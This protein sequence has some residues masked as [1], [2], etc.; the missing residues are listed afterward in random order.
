MYF[1]VEPGACTGNLSEIGIIRRDR[2]CGPYLSETEPAEHKKAGYYC[3]DLIS[4]RDRDFTYL[5]LLSV[6]TKHT[7][8]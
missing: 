8:F 3:A 5:A 7:L 2:L 1:L 6:S 4:S